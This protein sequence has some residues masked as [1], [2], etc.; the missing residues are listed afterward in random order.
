M[1]ILSVIFACS[2]YA[3]DDDLVRAIAESNSQ[4][5]PDFVED[6][7]IDPTQVDAP[8]PARTP[9]AA[10]AQARSILS[11]G[12]RPILG[13]MQ[14]VPSWL[15]AFG[16][17]LPDAFDPCTNVAIGTAM[18]STFDY[19]CAREGASPKA[20]PKPLSPSSREARRQ[21]VLGK[22]GEAIGLADFTT[23]T[24]LELRYQRPKATA[25]EGAPIFAAPSARAWGPDQLLVSTRPSS[26][27]PSTPP[28]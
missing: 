19:E 13:L 20:R 27:L 8:P 9:D 7:S 25:V 16:R 2:L 26:L 21:C 24:R 23:L 10:T 6:T 18:L 3:S 15:D 17:E 5:N 14:V 22:Y 1:D 28:P 4:S 12:G 11:S